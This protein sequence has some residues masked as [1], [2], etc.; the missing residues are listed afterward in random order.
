MSKGFMNVKSKFSINQG[1][2]GLGHFFQ[3]PSKPVVAAW[4]IFRV[5]PKHGVV[6]RGSEGE[7]PKYQPLPK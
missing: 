4:L 6:N 1:T 2:V 3:A 7:N 5:L